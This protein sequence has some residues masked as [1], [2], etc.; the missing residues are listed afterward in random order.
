MHRAIAHDIP[1][2]TCQKVTTDGRASI[3]VVL[4]HR[5]SNAAVHSR[6]AVRNI[7]IRSSLFPP[8]V[9]GGGDF[10]TIVYWPISIYF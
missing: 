1:Y 8:C 4:A 2:R 6:V 7:N 9:Y 3:T 10:A 5:A